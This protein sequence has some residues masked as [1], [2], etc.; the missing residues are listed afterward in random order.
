MNTSNEQ[1][2]KDSVPPH[3]PHYLL[4][5][6]TS[7]PSA[8]PSVAKLPT[9]YIV[10]CVH[11][12]T[13]GRTGRFPLSLAVTLYGC[14]QMISR[15]RQTPTDGSLGRRPEKIR[16]APTD[17]AP[18]D[19]LRISFNCFC[20]ISNRSTAPAEL[21]SE[22]ISARLNVVGRKLVKNGMAT[23]E[24]KQQAEGQ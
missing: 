21:R 8:A 7:L 18:G 2:R 16:F 20:T 17:Q 1:L 11:R 19:I 23:G 14:M 15:R 3:Q 9:R 22:F 12:E 4:P 24:Q 10:A 6:P 13:P 5:H